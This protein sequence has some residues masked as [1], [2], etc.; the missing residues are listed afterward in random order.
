M[1]GRTIGGDIVRRLQ[2]LNE[3]LRDGKSVTE[4]FTCRRVILK[5]DPQE[6]DPQMVKKARR[7][8]GLSQALFAQFLGYSASTVRAWEQGANSVPLPACRVMDE[9]RLCP[10]YWKKRL[11][12]SMIE[13]SCESA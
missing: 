7:I 13:K 11:R 5:L 6:Y 12:D 3:T 1:N 8:L 2:A 9:I 10:D 4:R